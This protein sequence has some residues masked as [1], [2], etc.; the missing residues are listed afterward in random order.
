MGVAEV[1]ARMTKEQVGQIL[2]ERFSEW[3]FAQHGDGPEESA[4]FY[5]RSQNWLI[6]R[7]ILHPQLYARERRDFLLNFEDELGGFVRGKF[8]G[9]SSRITQQ[10]LLAT[11]ESLMNKN[12]RWWDVSLSNRKESF[13]LEFQSLFPESC[14]GEIVQKKPNKKTATALPT[15]SFS[16]GVEFSSIDVSGTNPERR[17]FG[18]RSNAAI[19]DCNSYPP[20]KVP[21]AR[22]EAELISKA[23]G[24]GVRKKP[25]VGKHSSG[26]AQLLLMVFI[27]TI[28]VAYICF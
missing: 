13:F 2:D 18:A 16:S 1:E 6:D 5:E 20:P 12:P 26:C 11:M 24:Q 27:A 9:N 22:L 8:K 23:G 7:L 25:N 3:W 10:K 28:L 14:D 17:S 15:G 21:Y 4:W 19:F